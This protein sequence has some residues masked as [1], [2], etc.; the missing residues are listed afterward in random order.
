MIDFVKRHRAELERIHAAF[1]SLSLSES[2]AEDATATPEARTKAAQDVQTT[3]Q[4]FLKETG[5]HPSKIKATAGTLMYRKYNPVP[6]SVRKRIARR[7][8]VPAHTSRDHEFTDWAALDRLVDPVIA[9]GSIA[10]QP[11]LA[12]GS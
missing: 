3:I 12:P 6:G 7:A 10:I 2:G 8:G 5:W 11:S 9:N 1:V 4:R